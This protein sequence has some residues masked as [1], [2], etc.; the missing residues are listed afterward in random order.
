MHAEWALA[1]NGCHLRSSNKAVSLT[2]DIESGLDQGA[3]QIVK[4]ISRSL[5]QGIRQALMCKVS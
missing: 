3:C 1:V 2:A 5:S 4:P